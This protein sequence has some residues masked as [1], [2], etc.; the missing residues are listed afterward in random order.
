MDS[1]I[2]SSTNSKNTPHKQGVASGVVSKGK[3]STF[4]PL[5]GEL[6]TA[7]EL[8]VE[9]TFPAKVPTTTKDQPSKDTKTAPENTSSN[10]DQKPSSKQVQEFQAEPEEA[11]FESQ[12]QVED[13]SFNY[14]ED[15]FE[16]EKP[17]EDGA[18]KGE[19]PE[20][21]QDEISFPSKETPA[22]EAPV[23]SEPA[24][25]ESESVFLASIEQQSQKAA[26]ELPLQKDQVIVQGTTAPSSSDED[27]SE[28]LSSKPSAA[29]LPLK[30]EN[31]SQENTGALSKLKTPLTSA[32]S[33]QNTDSPPTSQTPTPLAQPS[34][35]QDSSIEPE[36]QQAS[37]LIGSKELQPK[38]P[39][40]PQA[41]IQASQTPIENLQTVQTPRE[42]QPT[43]LQSSL[44]VEEA[45]PLS[46]PEV[47]AASDSTSQI[48][49]TSDFTSANPAFVQVAVNGIADTSANTSLQKAG[50]LSRISPLSNAAETS[51]INSS[52]KGENFTGTGTDSKNSEFS[53]FKAQKNSS[54]GNA[55]SL[56]QT[57]QQ[58]VLQ[59]VAKAIGLR[60]AM[61]TN[62]RV[63]LLLR[64]E[65]L[66]QLELEL[67]FDAE[68]KLHIE[69]NAEKSGTRHL[70]LSS[71]QDL[72]AALR[73]E[74]IEL[75]RLIIEERHNHQNTQERNQ[76]QN[77][78]NKDSNSDSNK[79]N[80][81]EASGHNGSL[82]S[83]F[84]NEGQRAQESLELGKVNLQL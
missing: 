71:D 39:P 26:E 76:G 17:Q 28:P 60:S 8:K 36:V 32:A 72:R 29:P 66:G 37:D 35:A 23:E 67:E 54:S 11:S 43:T 31:A 15:S 63:S 58:Q 83:N 4:A 69:G 6:L 50:A 5:L 25:E 81:P 74:N 61:H 42:T 70:L 45:A 79:R 56:R 48:N 57:R 78:A 16:S 82:N 77:Q 13:D 19:T 24:L 22:L 18:F 1:R 46:G 2:S 34:I 33:Q 84:E 20:N 3:S 62:G 55:S 59:Q 47:Q 7:T 75:G 80:A 68:G 40:T 27:V 14:S 21:N 52:S 64:P 30:A 49:Q 38:A 51:S 9:T 12:D 10:V 73:Q 41:P 65:S 44:P 53:R